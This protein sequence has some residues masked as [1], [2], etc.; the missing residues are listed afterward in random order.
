MS[1]EKKFEDKRTSSRR[2]LQIDYESEE[3]AYK[4]VIISVKYNSLIKTSAVI[5]LSIA[6]AVESAYL[7]NL[8]KACFFEEPP[9][10]YTCLNTK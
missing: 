2:L 9:S 1:L 5:A 10:S 7:I 8:S 3:K 6:L 4:E